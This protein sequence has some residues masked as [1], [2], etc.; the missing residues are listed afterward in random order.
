MQT[1]LLFIITGLW[2]VILTAIVAWVF[3]FFNRLTGSA[4][5]GNLV[6]TLESILDKQ[7]GTEARLKSL[8]KE[9]E[10][11]DDEGNYHIQK[12]GL[13]RFNPFKE[14]GGDHSF[15]L[16]LLDRKDNGFILTGLHTRERTRVYIKDVK[17]GKSVIE[18]S[19]EEEKALNLALIS[20]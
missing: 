8:E 6:R 4:K 3:I 16:S 11:I 1:T 17:K 14:T 20:K 12:V 5:R 18:L 13:V 19:K 15:S 7:K 9:L 10:R 2:L